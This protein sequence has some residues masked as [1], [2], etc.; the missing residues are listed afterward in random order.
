LYGDLNVPA[1]QYLAACQI[2]RFVP[3]CQKTAVM[4]LRPDVRVKK[5]LTADE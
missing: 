5:I 3:A 1:M 4:F 2:A